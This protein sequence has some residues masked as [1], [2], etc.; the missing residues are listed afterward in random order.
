MLQLYGEQAGHCQE[1]REGWSRTIF[2]TAVLMCHFTIAKSEHCLACAHCAEAARQGGEP[3]HQEP[4]DGQGES[5]PDGDG[6][7]HD[8][9]VIMK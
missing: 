1:Q 8:G 7:D 2:N 4:P 9:E 5:E 6:V 3:D